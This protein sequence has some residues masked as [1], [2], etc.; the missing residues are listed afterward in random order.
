[1]D[2]F[3]YYLFSVS[4]LVPF[5]LR[6]RPALPDPDDECILE[7]AMQSRAMIGT[8]NKSD[9]VGAECFGVPVKSPA[10]FLKLL[11]ATP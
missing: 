5:V 1:V 11:G 6:R 7:V 2:E 4:N 8:H 9:F 10:E 3:L